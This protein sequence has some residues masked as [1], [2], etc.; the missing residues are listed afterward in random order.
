MIAQTASRRH[1]RIVAGAAAT[2][3]ISRP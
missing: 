1:R 3:E 2:P